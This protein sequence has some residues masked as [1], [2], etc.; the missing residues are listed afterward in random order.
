MSSAKGREDEEEAG[1]K[2]KALKF[3]YSVVLA[4]VLRLPCRS[5]GIANE[6][7]IRCRHGDERTKGR[8]DERMRTMTAVCD[9]RDNHCNEVELMIRIHMR[10]NPYYDIIYSARLR[11]APHINSDDIRRMM[12]KVVISKDEKFIRK[13]I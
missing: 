9:E 5:D 11:P 3:D 7:T 2:L 13:K 6:A 1:Y 10:H 8:D 12:D 4:H